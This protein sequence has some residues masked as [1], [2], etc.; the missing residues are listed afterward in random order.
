MRIVPSL[1]LATL[2]FACGNDDKP[3]PP[4][5]EVRPPVRG[6]VGD[7]DLRVMLAEIASSKA[8]EMIKGSFRPL[9]GTKDPSLVTGLLWIRDCK[10]TNQGTNVTYELAGEGWQWAEQT[11]KKAGGTFEMR[12]YVT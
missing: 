5:P 2:C 4:A 10:I 12:D 1:V 7:Q 3:L 11:K 9:Q 6:A 8:C